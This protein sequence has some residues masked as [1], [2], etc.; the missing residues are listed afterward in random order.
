MKTTLGAKCVLEQRSREEGP[1]PSIA[2]KAEERKD[3]HDLLLD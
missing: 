3:G 2:R 1:N